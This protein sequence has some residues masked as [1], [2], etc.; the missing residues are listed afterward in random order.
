MGQWGG[1]EEGE[2]R[3]KKLLRATARSS[4]SQTLSQSPKLEA[5]QLGPI[6]R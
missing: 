3:N 2:I 1:M 5:N 6:W 4:S